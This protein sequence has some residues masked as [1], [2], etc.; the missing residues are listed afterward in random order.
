MICLFE[1]EILREF[2]I[3]HNRYVA[4]QVALV[5][6]ITIRFFSNLV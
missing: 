1:V 4:Y 6:E 5:G 2:G 3:K